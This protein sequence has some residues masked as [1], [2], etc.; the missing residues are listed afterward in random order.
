MGH[1]AQ[2]VSSWLNA[3]DDLAT[4]CEASPAHD[5][6]ACWNAFAGL[7]LSAPLDLGG[8]GIDAR[9]IGSMATMVELGALESAC[10]AAL[11]PQVG[12]IASRGPGGTCL[13][14]VVLPGGSDEMTGTGSSLA[15]ALMGSTL[16]AIA[17]ACRDARLG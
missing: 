5:Q 17:D 10:L 16:V 14:T 12:Y 15:L 13:A 11:G 2:I 9:S 6:Q 3:L 7:I 1:R 4:R 8:Y